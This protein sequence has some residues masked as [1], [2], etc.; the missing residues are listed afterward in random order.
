MVS[1]TATEHLRHGTK[2]STNSTLV[3]HRWISD[4]NTSTDLGAAW[5]SNL[6]FGACV[7]ALRYPL[8]ACLPTHGMDVSK[9]SA[10]EQ[11]AGLAQSADRRTLHL[12]L[13]RRF[14]LM[15]ICGI[16]ISTGE[17]WVALGGSLAVA[18]YNLGPP[19]VLYGLIV[20][21][22][23]YWFVAASVAKL[24]SAM[25]SSGTVY[26][27]ASIT[28]GPRYERI[29]GFF[30][31]WW[32][33]LACVTGA[34]SLTSF[35]ALQVLAMYSTIHPDYTGQNWHVL[36]SFLLCTWLCSLVVLFGNRLLPFIESVGALI[37]TGGFLISILACAI[38]PKIHGKAYASSALVWK[39]GT[40]ETGWSCQTF[41]FCLGMLNAAFAVGAPGIPSHL[42]EEM[43]RSVL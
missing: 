38:M 24:A 14:N 2:M 39:V 1:C 5:L 33:F 10:E 27:W 30:A 42:A 22:F 31:G 4:I 40:N 12:Q 11:A 25:P 21:S 3:F 35:M 9:P 37:S 32:N 19:G 16:A 17:S 28:A 29:C 15:S 7:P 36:V 43:P 18:I 23:F 6:A 20:T 34:A 26:H 13:D 41:V 8:S